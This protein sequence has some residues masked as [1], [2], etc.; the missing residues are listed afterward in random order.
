[1]KWGIK[2]S[3]GYSSERERDRD[4]RVCRNPRQR[5]WRSSSPLVDLKSYLPISTTKEATEIKGQS[6]NKFSFHFIEI[7]SKLLHCINI[8][9]KNAWR[10]SKLYVLTTHLLNYKLGTWSLLLQT[11]Y[12]QFINI[13]ITENILLLISACPWATM[14]SKDKV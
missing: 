1:M 14:S 12:N 13:R 9:M 2:D 10:V 11:K 5:I 8:C 4:G 7:W 6:I 3:N